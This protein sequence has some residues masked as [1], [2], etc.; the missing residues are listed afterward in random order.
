MATSDEIEAV[1]KELAQILVHTS[2]SQ[3]NTVRILALARRLHE[4][5]GG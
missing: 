3:W 5:T 4:L 1:A 2:P